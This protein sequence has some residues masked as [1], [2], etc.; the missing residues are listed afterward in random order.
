MGL[1]D[2]DIG[3]ASQI[4]QNAQYAQS[5][6]Q[7]GRLKKDYANS[8]DEELMSACKEFEKYFIEQ[9]FKEAQKTIMKDDSGLSNSDATARSIYE[10]NLAKELSSMASDQQNVGLAKTLYEQMKR[11]Q[12]ISL[13]EVEAREAAKQAK[14]TETNPQNTETAKEPVIEEVNTAGEQTVMSELAKDVVNA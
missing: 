6:G 5:A 2:M 14:N 4:A 3:Y 13:E 10:D 8:S 12:G 11:S 7:A 9:V 1:A